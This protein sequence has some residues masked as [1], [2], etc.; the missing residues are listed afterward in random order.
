MIYQLVVE[1]GDA[2]YDFREENSLWAI[3]R[4]AAG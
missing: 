3:A 1:D 4:S 2:R